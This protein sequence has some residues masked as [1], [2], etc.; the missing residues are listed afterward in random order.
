MAVAVLN[1]GQLT[2]VSALVKRFV[3]EGYTPEQARKMVCRAA[4]RTIGKPGVRAHG[5]WGRRPHGQKRRLGGGLSGAVSSQADYNR[6]D[7]VQKRAILLQS[8]IS[9]IGKE[10]WDRA[11]D[12]P[13]VIA[14][15]WAPKSNYT[16]DNMMSFWLNN[17]KSIITTASRP[18]TVEQVNEVDRLAAGSEK[19]L[20]LVKQNVSS[21]AAAAAEADR[22]KAASMMQGKMMSPGSEGWKTFQSELEAR[23][24]SLVSGGMGIVTMAV[25]AAGIIGV[26][27][28]V[29][30]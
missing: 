28:A 5:Q 21:E 27:Y 26:A 3:S 13:A 11:L 8:E 20:A 6:L 29:T 25:I 19:L 7:Q 23:A 10:E 2:A 22:A 16:Y 14:A 4:A 15:G 17:V 1:P 24:K 9:G 30:R 18:A 12:A